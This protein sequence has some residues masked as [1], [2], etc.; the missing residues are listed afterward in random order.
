MAIIPQ[1]L[2]QKRP[3]IPQTLAQYRASRK[4]QVTK[5]V[6][7]ASKEVTDIIQQQPQ[8]V[9]DPNY[10]KD[11]TIAI[12]MA[13]TGRG[14][15]NASGRAVLIN[16]LIKVPWDKR[17]SQFSPQEQQL[18]KRLHRD[19]QAGYYEKQQASQEVEK[20]LAARAAA[21]AATQP[22]ES[23]SPFGAQT[24]RQ[25]LEQAGFKLKP[26]VILAS[27]TARPTPT[28]LPKGYDSTTGL[29]TSTSPTGERATLYLRPP[30]PEEQQ[31]INLVKA[32][33]SK[34]E[35][36]I[37]SFFTGSSLPE[38]KESIRKK[39]RIKDV[40]EWLAETGEKVSEGVSKKLK[41]RKEEEETLGKEGEQLTMRIKNFNE[42]YARHPKGGLELQQY[43]QELNS[44]NLQVENYN[45]KFKDYQNKIA[46]AQEKPVI[47]IGGIGLLK[48][49]AE[50]GTSFVKGFV[51]SP[52]SLASFGLGLVT[53]PGE[54]ISQMITGMGQLPTQLAERP[55]TTFGQ[56]SGQ[57][58]GQSLMFKGLG[59]IKKSQVASEMK[60]LE[61][62]K[63]VFVGEEIGKIEGGTIYKSLYGRETPLVT[64]R[65]QVVS[66][67]FRIGDKTIS[68]TGTRATSTITYKNPLTGSKTYTDTFSLGA[69]AS[70]QKGGTISYGGEVSALPE[71]FQTFLGKGYIKRTGAE[72]FKKFPVSGAVTEQGGFSFVVSTEPS[73]VRVSLLGEGTKV[74]SKITGA[75]IIKSLP[76]T[77]L[78]GA[79]GGA[80]IISG[81]GKKTPFSTTF[82][83]QA[84]APSVFT[85]E[86]VKQVAKESISVIKPV[87]KPFGFGTV[88]K[89]AIS[90]IIE[91]QTQEP[92]IVSLP[93][94][95]IM[96]R[97]LM[98]TSLSSGQESVV[99]SKESSA[100]VSGLSNISRSISKQEDTSR[101][102]F[103]P[104]TA[105]AVS[106]GEAT[107]T[108][109]V[110]PFDF[111]TQAPPIPPST[112]PSGFGF[113]F[114]GEKPVTRKEQV[115]E[116]FARIDATKG[117]KAYWK[118]V[119]P[120]STK[121]GA[122]DLASQYVDRNISARFKVSPATKE[123]KGK[124]QFVEVES[125]KL[126]QGNDYWNKNQSKFRTFKQKKGQR[127]K[128]PSGA[129]EKSAYR[130][131]S[132]GEK[133]KIK[134]ARVQASS[135][136]IGSFGSGN[137][138]KKGFKKQENFRL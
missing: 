44:L 51:E 5:A 131:D 76:D 59:K 29:I 3:Q 53:Q 36:Q 89:T 4:A 8:Q 34:K 104:A 25:M 130:L 102:S 91:K 60:K 35:E 127:T 38:T 108:K 66:P 20:F 125:T 135:L 123:V 80:T 92:K 10:A 94:Q 118:K 138:T 61:S 117:E 83:E 54:E 137:S 106:L 105:Q 13:L 42:R 132:P 24:E 18:I 52:F 56:L 40:K 55:V 122:V 6:S 100:L 133:K 86:F 9:A 19:V 112:I 88:G 31:R 2:Q 78:G 110:Q 119:T 82:V 87:P 93:K 101:T 99:K 65:V 23:A 134:Q 115:Y 47:T 45:K 26:G 103:I 21:K 136:L 81:G 69:K 113:V 7:V 37:S 126:F 32:R 71:S 41:L 33:I 85:G 30:T 128:L 84:R 28:S 111:I 27:E 17:I 98:T 39:E 70:I 109:Q 63:F 62:Q 79:G 97:N 14:V 90:T 1:Q 50:F 68:T 15:A 48:G 46:I 75:G 116:G 107:A 124:K 74:R 121:K 58:A 11:W 72:S 96:T 77:E 49:G 129:I 95:E 22:V 64:Q 120:K 16:T 12:K 73:K 67:T 43:N 114:P 57:I